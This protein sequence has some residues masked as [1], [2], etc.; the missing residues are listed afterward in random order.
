MVKKI[1]RTK[2]L[3][4]RLSEAEYA[5]FLAFCEES[6]ISPSEAMRRF[7]RAAVGFGP[8]FESEAAEAIQAWTEELGAIRFHIMGMTR[9]INGG[10]APEITPLREVLQEFYQTLIEA[11]AMFTSL[12]HKARS[13]ARS[14]LGE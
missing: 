6:S 9:E 14:F 4:F 12:R 11:E 13:W 5:H 10:R 8:T 1:R 7:A 2:T 3:K